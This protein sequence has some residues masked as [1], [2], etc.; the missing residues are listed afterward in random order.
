MKQSTQKP[1]NKNLSYALRQLLLE[2]KAGT[3]ED[4]CKTLEKQGYIVNQPKISRLLTKIGA[5]KIQNEEGQNIYRLPHEHG[6]MHEF[7]R[8]SSKFAIK[9]WVI[10]IVSNS[11]LIVIHTTPGAAGLVAREIDINHLKLG[12]MG[13]IAGDDTIFIAPKDVKNIKRII[14]G[15]KAILDL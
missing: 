6:L 13:T 2:G 14:D 9:E 5:I 10:D 3:H 11:H 4:I 15:V 12:I 7:N 8:P 1:D